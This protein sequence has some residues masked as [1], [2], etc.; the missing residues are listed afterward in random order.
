MLYNEK[1]RKDGAVVETVDVDD[2]QVST[3]FEFQR[4]TMASIRKK[5]VRRVV[6]YGPYIPTLVRLLEEGYFE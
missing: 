6:E 3:N 4:M 1:A 5:Q 2:D